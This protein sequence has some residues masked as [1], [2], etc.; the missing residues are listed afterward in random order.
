MN[1]RSSLQQIVV[2]G[3]GLVATCAAIGFARALPRA[4]VTQIAIPVD[5]AA[6]A[7]RF[8]AV[9]ARGLVL[10]ARLG[11]SEDALVAAGAATHRVGTR[12]DWGAAPFAIGEGEGTATLA[13]AALHQLWRAHGD[14]PFDALVP[15]AALATQERFV[16]PSDDAGS[17]LSRIDYALRLDAACAAPL[18]AG[19]ARAAGVRT[20]AAQRTAAVYE[21]S[22][23]GGVTVDG[24]TL[25]ADLFI[26][27]SGPAA[28]LAAPSTAWIDWHA[29]L[30]ADRLLLA[31][32]PARPSPTDGYEAVG[33]G[34]SARW[35]LASRTLR[36]FAYTAAVTNDARAR[37]LFPHE[38][39]RIA[40]HARR[41]EAPFT[42]NVLAIGDAAAALGPLGW[43]GLP[44][45]LV[46][47]ELALEL[48]P[49]R[50]DGPRLAV[51][52]NRRA[53]L[54]ADRMHAYAAAFYLA[55]AARKGPFWHAARRALPPEELERALAQ[56]GRR[57]T[58]PPLDEAMIPKALW[59][60]ALIGLG[61]RPERP[62]PVALS[63]PRASAVAALA[64]WRAAVGG[65]A[66][67]LPPYP[68]YL[69]RLMR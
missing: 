21:E 45:A 2:V 50:G 35:P 16:H 28:C 69:A 64:Q 19:A 13:G 12:F 43:L 33:D 30:P 47:I 61:V 18:L 66:P 3:G 55:G 6:C 15:G 14:G 25:A 57:G 34:W 54:A 56:F 26:D 52:Y 1:D 27:A 53:G 39:E 20:V 60:Q 41:Q 31:V 5:P 29:T 17:L 8:P 11:I 59:Q 51:E 38:A 24:A 36:G 65:L 22:R 49:A 63:V 37:R 44:L 62:D 23:L 4:V 67:S 46:Q 9:D 58:L 40:L 10:L 68:D 7:D 48:M 32:G 42:G